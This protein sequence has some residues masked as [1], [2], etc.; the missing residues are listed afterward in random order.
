[1]ISPVVAPNFSRLLTASDAKQLLKRLNS[2]ES[3]KSAAPIN[4]IAQL[5]L[6]ELSE[7]WQQLIHAPLI[8]SAEDKEK[9]ATDW[10]INLFNMLF[11]HQQV[12]LVRGDSEPEYFPAKDNE[13]ARI[14]F[15]HGFFQSAL[16]E[17]SHWC[18]AG[19]ERRR[20]SDFGY[21]YAPDGRT[22]AQQQ[23]FERVEIKPQ[24]LECLFTL[25]CNRNFQVSQDNLF[26]DFDTSSSTFAQDVYQQAKNYITDPHTLPRDAKTLLQALL[27]I[28]TAD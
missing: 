18:V 23:A 3:K 27:R 25:A 28:C 7:Q 15:A 16:H 11:S 2:L 1:M 4:P 14:E 19:K 12:I 22:K 17:L 13:A 9:V 5:P 26:A 20:L 21:W 10:L 6:Q 8:N 24:A